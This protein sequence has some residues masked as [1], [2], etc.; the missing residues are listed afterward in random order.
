[1][2]ASA[3]AVLLLHL[4]WILWVIFGALWTRGRPFLTGFHIA[5]I[6]W[7]ILVELSPWPCPLTLLEQYFEVKAGATPYT[8]S[9]LLHY[10]DLLVYPHVNEL[11]LT[12]AG[13][14]IC[15][16]NLFIYARRLHSWRSQRAIH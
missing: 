12:W 5:S 10:L 14:A 9:F 8:G 11:L 3:E 4:G 2:Q 16:A 7:G 15:G 1:M 13:V 6:V